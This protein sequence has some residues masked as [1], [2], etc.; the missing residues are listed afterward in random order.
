MS[1]YG[2]V[3]AFYKTWGDYDNPGTH[4][5]ELTSRKCTEEEIGVDHAEGGTK[6]WPLHF[7]QAHDHTS[8]EK[9]LQCIEENIEI[10]GN[11][12]SAVTQS[13]AIQFVACDSTVRSDCKTNEEIHRY[14]ARKFIVTLENHSRFNIKDYDHSRIT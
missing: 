3:K 7:N 5:K 8:I 9:K 2:E 12:N 1:T 10:S 14:M 13:L 11:F 6:F 4:Y